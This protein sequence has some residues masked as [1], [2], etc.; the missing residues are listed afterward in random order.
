MKGEY[1]KRYFRHPGTVSNWWDLDDKPDWLRKIFEKKHFFVRKLFDPRGKVVLDAG[2]GKGRFA[3]D[4][5]L[6]GAKQ[7]FALDIS[8]EMLQIAKEKAR[9]AGVLEKITF[10]TGD[11]ENLNL[12]DNIFD[13]SVCIGT[14]VHLPNPHKAAAELTRVT[15]PNGEILADVTTTLKSTVQMKLSTF[16]N[17]AIVRHMSIDEFQHLFTEN[18][19]KIVKTVEWIPWKTMKNYIISAKNSKF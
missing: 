3:I 1:V 9:K 10:I 12:R 17:K 13:A 4:F 19:L 15:K 7:V 18:G 14:F 6:A 2:A 16:E 8:G 5:A 11:A